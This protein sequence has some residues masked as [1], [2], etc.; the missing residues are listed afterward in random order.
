MFN[1]RIDSVLFGILMFGAML[2][3]HLLCAMAH[4]N[5]DSPP[6][7]HAPAVIEATTSIPATTRE[8]EVRGATT[9]IDL[10][11][12]VPAALAQ[13]RQNLPP[14]CVVREGDGYLTI[15]VGPTHVDVRWFGQRL[16]IFIT[17]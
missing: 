11:T 12:D 1:S 4:N 13:F 2:G 3:I 5:A 17:D 16:L 14:H 9:I 15:M 8:T 10:R 6:A 7:G